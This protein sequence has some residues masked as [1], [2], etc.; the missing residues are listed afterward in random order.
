MMIDSFFSCLSADV[1]VKHCN[2]TD[3]WP[4]GAYSEKNQL[5][6]DKNE[7]KLEKNIK[8]HYLKNQEIK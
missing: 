7:W 2:F 4:P 8:E 5:K 6:S 1:H 3:Q